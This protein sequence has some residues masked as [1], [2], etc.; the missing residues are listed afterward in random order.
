MSNDETIRDGWVIP[1]PVAEYVKVLSLRDY[2]A[3]QML[4][5]I[6]VQHGQVALNDRT[7]IAA[8]C[9][10]LADAMLDARTSTHGVLQTPRATPAGFHTKDGAL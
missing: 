2:F 5:G 8:G 3:G 10:A 7:E 9:Y 4:A 6:A 1:P